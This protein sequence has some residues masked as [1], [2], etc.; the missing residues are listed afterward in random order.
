MKRLIYFERKKILKRKSTAI[1]CLCMI[2]GIFT[3]SVIFITDQSCFTENGA[4]VNGL[5]AIHRNRER[6]HALAGLLTGERLKEILHRYQAAYGNPDNY[7]K[8]SVLKEEIYLREIIP[9]YGIISLMRRVYSPAGTYDSEILL[10]VTDE[11][12]EQFY[13]TRHAQVWDN[14]NKNDSA[15]FYTEAEKEKIAAL[16]GEV[17]EPFVYDYTDGWKTLLVRGFGIMFL[18][19]LLVVCVVLSPVFAY[20]YQTGMDAAILSSRCGRRKTVFAKIA[21]GIQIT[22]GIYLLAVMASF[23][24]VLGIFGIQGWNCNYQLLSITSFYDLKI[25]QAALVGIIL[26]YLVTLSVMAFVMLLS[27]ACKTPFQAVIISMLYA[28]FAVFFPESNINGFVNRIFSLLPAK[29]VDTHTVF[30]SYVLFSFGKVV[31][32]L[33]CMI[34]I[35]AVL[36]IAVC[37]PVAGRKFRMH[38]VI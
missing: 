7:A 26:N 23:F 27:A 19:A 28:V 14:A 38:Q 21:A 1:A 8:E 2:L 35:S 30:S 22:S 32:T 17:S 29:A 10:H 11:M 31:I 5:E 3:F 15:G 13:E 6:D 37:L 9:Y 34:L 20:E 36:I 12:A 25:W 4:E 18:L 33:P 24:G 16:D